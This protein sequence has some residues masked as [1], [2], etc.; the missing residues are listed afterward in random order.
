[1]RVCVCVTSDES[2]FI[3]SILRANLNFP[4]T[5]KFSTEQFRIFS[6]FLALK[7]C[8][9]CVQIIFNK[10]K[11]IAFLYDSMEYSLDGAMELHRY[12]P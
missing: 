1:M 4:Q 10:T 11:I 9:V 7:R 2:V 12:F 6:V 5:R 3:V 8:I